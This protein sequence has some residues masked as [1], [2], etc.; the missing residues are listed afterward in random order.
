MTFDSWE[1]LLELLFCVY[2]S[3]SPLIASSKG[4][5]DDA[6]AVQGATNGPTN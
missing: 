3:D 4:K 5:P 1:I 2:L 6:A